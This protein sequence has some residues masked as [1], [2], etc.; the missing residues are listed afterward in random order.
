MSWGLAPR[1][2]R[3]AVATTVEYTAFFG[4]IFSN[5]D[6]LFRLF[7]ELYLLATGTVNAG[8]SAVTTTVNRVNSVLQ[9]DVSNLFFSNLSEK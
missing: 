9:K 3:T 6:F 1:R 2:L 8:L 7:A 5:F 4:G